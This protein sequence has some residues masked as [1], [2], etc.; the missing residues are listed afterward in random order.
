MQFNCHK[1]VAMLLGAEG[2]LLSCSTALR[3]SR[4]LPRVLQRKAYFQF[5]KTLVSKHLITKAMVDKLPEVIL[6]E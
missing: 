3:F 4:G 2:A 6:K 5:E 1:G